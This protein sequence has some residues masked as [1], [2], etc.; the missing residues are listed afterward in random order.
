M[1]YSIMAT[2]KHKKPKSKKSTKRFRRTR[3]KR[4]RGG[5]KTKKTLDLI[6]AVSNGNIN[7]VR[8]IVEVQHANVNAAE[9]SQD[10]R[11]PR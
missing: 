8:R 11:S 10:A 7:K 2:R 4:Q 6:D 3:S 1:L 9:K 5:S